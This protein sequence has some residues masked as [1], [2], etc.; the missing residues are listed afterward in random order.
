[1]EHVRILHLA[2]TTMEST[3][4]DALALLLELD[5]PFDYGSARELATP[6]APLAP[7]LTL[8]AGPGLLAYDRLLTGSLL[9]PEVAG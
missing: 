7:A 1:M 6:A 9:A 4:D 8:A 2:A 3:V 5:Q